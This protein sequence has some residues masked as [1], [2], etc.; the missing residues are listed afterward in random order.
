MYM[1]FLMSFIFS[2]TVLIFFPPMIMFLLS[3]EKE[4]T[5][6]VWG[7]S[8]IVNTS[9]TYI[10]MHTQYNMWGVGMHMCARHAH[11]CPKALGYSLP[12]Q[13]Q[14]FLS[15]VNSQTPRNLRPHFWKDDLLELNPQPSTK[16]SWQ[17][18][19]PS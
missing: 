16:G 19:I 10:H 17:V 2:Y 12:S 1:G 6:I 7:D 8:V 18:A 4:S 13:P 15:L 3:P 14:S 9:Q 5:S 11:G